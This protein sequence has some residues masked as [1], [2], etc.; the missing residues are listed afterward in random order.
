MIGIEIKDNLTLINAI[1]KFGEDHQKTMAIEELSELQIAICHER[2]GRESN[3][4]EEIADVLI[5]CRQLM[6][7]YGCDIEVQDWIDNKV[8]RLKER[9]GE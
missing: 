1:R 4:P 7:I 8:E 9:I 6:E 3:V 2:R 5:M